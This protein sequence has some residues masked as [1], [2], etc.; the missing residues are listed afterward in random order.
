MRSNLKSTISW[1]NKNA[2]DFAA[3]SE[4]YPPSEQIDEFCSYVSKNGKILDVGCGG[5]RDAKIFYGKGYEVTGVDLS[6]GLLKIARKKY[7]KIDFIKGNFLKLPFKNMS[8]DGVWA[9]ASLVHL[10]EDKDVEKALAE[11]NRVLKKDGVLHVAV[12]EVG[13]RNREGDT[14]FF[15]GFTLDELQ[16][17]LE[18]SGFVV[19]KMSRVPSRKNPNATW[20]VALANKLRRL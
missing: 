3:I 17:F 2:K 1:Y 16:S 10:E 6:S 7:P 4:K 13:S 11:F 9:H 14:R 5:G 15:R 19:K 18:K 20:L 8:F 12:K